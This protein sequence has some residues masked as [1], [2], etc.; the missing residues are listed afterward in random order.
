MA[1]VNNW[2]AIVGLKGRATFGEEHRWFV[3]YYLDVGT[4]ESSLT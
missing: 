1:S 3:P 4:G 2:D